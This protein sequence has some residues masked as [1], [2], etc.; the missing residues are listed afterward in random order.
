M[1]K[2][3][4]QRCQQGRVAATSQESEIGEGVNTSEAQTH[5]VRTEHGEPVFLGPG[6]AAL[7][8]AK[9]ST[10]QICDFRH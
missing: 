2:E 4:R 6:G 5:T 8:E 1:Q 7:S 3:G 10:L 9:G